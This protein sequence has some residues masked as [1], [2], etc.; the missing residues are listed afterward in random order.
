MPKI[1]K[2]LIDSVA[3]GNRDTFH[4]DNELAGYG[5][6]VTPAG[7]KVFVLQYRIG[8]QSRRMTLGVFGQLTADQARSEARAALRKVARGDDPM[9][10][11]DIKRDEKTMGQLLDQFLAQ[12]VE[13]KLKSRSSAE[14]KRLVETLVPAKLLR[15]LISEVSRAHISQL[16]HHNAKTP[17]QAN[18]L[19]AVMRKFFNWCEKNGFR[20]DHTN[21]ALHVDLFKERKRDRFLSPAEIS[22]LGEVLAA[23]EREGRASPFVVA[24]IR[25]LVLTGARLN[26]V[27]SARWQWVDFEGCCIRLPDSKT[28]AKTVYLSAPA[29]QVL[30]TIPRLEDNPHIICGQKAGSSL[31]NLQ[32]PWSAIR[33]RAGFDDLRIHDLRHSFASIAVANGMS[34]PMI[35]KLLGH[36]QPQTTARYAHLADDPMKHAADQIGSKIDILPKLHIVS[37]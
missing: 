25:L 30:T 24:A 15:L 1:T 16:H 11:R 37:A 6:K 34:L 5:L 22:H 12:H 4:W 23:V 29:L 28:G 2:R 9:A 31:V 27:L 14:Y 33:T 21:P 3:A 20:P 18:R 10:E 8:R 13:A 17:Y 26:E 35:G 19:L 32:K 7:R 36:S